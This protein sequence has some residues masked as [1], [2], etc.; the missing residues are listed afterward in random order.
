MYGAGVSAGSFIF[1]RS[2]IFQIFNAKNS[3]IGPAP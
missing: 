3:K 2:G 1:H